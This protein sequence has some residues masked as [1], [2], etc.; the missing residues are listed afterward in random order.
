MRPHPRY[1]TA[2][3]AYGAYSGGG[4]VEWPAGSLDPLQPAAAPGGLGA[5]LD[6]DAKKVVDVIGST[7]G[8][9]K[10]IFKVPPP[11]RTLVA[12]AVAIA[13]VLS[14]VLRGGRLPQRGGRR[15]PRQSSSGRSTRRRRGR[16][17]RAWTS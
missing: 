4:A 13:V 17:R 3:D 11:R 6:A 5:P 1:D 15:R 8:L 7:F 9:G 12:A 14:Y 2:G 16:A 10:L